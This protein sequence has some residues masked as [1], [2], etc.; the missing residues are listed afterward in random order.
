MISTATGPVSVARTSRQPSRSTS[1]SDLTRESISGSSSSDHQTLRRSN[2]RVIAEPKAAGES[3]TAV[4]R[5]SFPGRPQPPAGSSTSR[6]E[7]VT[8]TSPARSEE[9]LPDDRDLG[10]PVFAQYGTPIHR[11][12][13]TYT[14]I[15]PSS[16]ALEH[17]S[18]PSASGEAGY[19]VH[20]SVNRFR[21]LLYEVT[22]ETEEAIQLAQHDGADLYPDEELSHARSYESFSGDD[23]EGDFVP[24]VGRIIQRMPTIES[25]GSRE[26]MSLS[27]GQ[28]GDNSNSIHSLS[29]P[30]T[31]SNT[32]S[33]SE[34]AGS[35]PVS[36]SNSLTASVI[37]AS[38]VDG[39]PPVNELGELVK[40]HGNSGY[41][42]QQAS[43]STASYY[44][45]AGSDL[46]AD[47]AAMR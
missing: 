22:R 42:S 46:G 24:V 4:G 1:E 12:S 8:E 16:L 36:R 27:S 30:P 3:R 40:P 29:R 34:A 9:D 47:R 45:A 15:P 37:L 2:S 28:R 5:Q 44:T 25:L 39:H 20:M 13:G 33:L 23:E 18:E 11:H 19:D 10:S 17:L 31:R 6:A 21:D 26:I 14:V 38:P 41:S 32:L 35:Q 43:R 7:D